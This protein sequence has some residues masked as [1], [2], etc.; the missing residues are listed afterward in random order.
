MDSQRATLAQATLAITSRAMPLFRY[1]PTVDGVFGS[2][3]S[4]DGNPQISETMV[5]DADG[6]RALTPADWAIG[7]RRFRSNFRPLPNDATAPLAL[8]EWLQ[9]DAR[10]R[11]RK[12]PYVAV[13]AGEEERRYSMAPAMID[14]AEQ[15][16]QVWQTLQELA[17]VVTPFTERLEQEIRAEVAAEHRAELDA[18][19]ADSEVR[20]QEIQEKIE[21][22]IASKIRSR[23]TALASRKRGWTSMK[24]L[25]L[26]RRNFEHGVHPAHH[27]NQ[28]E[29]LPIQRVPFVKDYVMP[30]GQHIGVPSRP[31]VA[32]GE[33]VLRGQL[34]AEPGGFVSTGLHSPV[35]GTVR[36]IGDF[37][38]VDGG[39]SAGNRDRGRCVRNA[40]GRSRRRDGLAIAIA[41]ELHRSGP[42][43]GHRRHGRRGI[44]GSREV[45]GA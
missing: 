23:L 35:T 24:P 4:L 32:V 8:H 28:T 11:E 20:I 13:G 26:L 31:I 1:D 6:E 25:G 38:G 41:R 39:F 22:E 2:R 14:M 40:T 18:Q 45:V 21:A 7:Q 34:I 29:D 5:P 36:K 43:G 3:I 30:L 27:K 16:L 10:S 9:L 17:G 19:A 33:R 37:R 12:T 42:D 44:P 15:C